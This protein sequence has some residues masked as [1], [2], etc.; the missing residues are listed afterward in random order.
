VGRW[1]N[2]KKDWYDIINLSFMRK[3]FKNFVIAA[4]SY[5]S[6]RTLRK[7]KP[8]VIAITGN[9]GKTTTKDYVFNF[10][11]YKFVNDSGLTVRESRKSENSEFGVNLTI[12]GEKNVWNNLFAWISMIVRNF[13]KLGRTVNYP[14]VLVLE[15]GADK[16]GDIRYIGS[17]VKP[18]LVVLTA[19]QKSPSHGEFFM[20]IEQHINEK[21]VLVEKMRRDGV[22]VYNSDDEVM[23]KIAL[24]KKEKNPKVR[25]FSF[26]KKEDS[27]I[28]ILENSNI[29]NEE[30][31]ILGLKIRF[32]VRFEDLRDEVEI[33]LT[34]I[35]GEAHTYSLASALCVAVLNEFKKEDLLNAA[36]QFDRS[37]VYSKSRM[38]ILD[39]INNS[40]IIDDSY[41]SSPK[42]AVNA[43]ETVSSILNKGK[44]IAIL[45]HMAELGQ[46]TADEHFKI[47]MLA[48]KHFDTIIFSGRYNDFFLEGVREAKTDLSKVF[49]AKDTAEVMRI[50]NDNSLIK[51]HDIILVKGSQSARLEKVVV[52]LLV[53]PRDRE[54]VCR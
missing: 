21:K 9:V 6:V 13:I 3:L 28:V 23:S 54:E 45:G 7:Y 20:N 12:L 29:Y 1:T 34:G 38:R 42:A 14:Q 17:I 15:V 8:I 51:E 43:I 27:N 37:S 31:E 50:L 36:R 25:I 5:L 39:G 33:R 32:G 30:A 48:A 47:G 16:P 2:R 11:K 35:V 52:G 22:I 46:K 53:N 44:K 41:N 24:E 10:L 26:G 19:F 4:L 49:L 40:K 18:D